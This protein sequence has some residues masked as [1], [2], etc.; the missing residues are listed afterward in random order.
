VVQPPFA[1]DWARVNPL[2]C[3]F[4]GDQWEIAIMADKSKIGV[5]LPTYVLKVERV[6]IRELMRAIGDDN[7]I[8]MDKSKAVA[9]AYLDTPC[10]PT[11][12]TMA[13]Q[14]FTGAYL[15]IFKMLD[16]PLEHV[17]HGEEEY[18]YTGEIFPGD[19]LSCNMSCESIVEK[20]TKSG[21]LDLIT[22]QTIFTNQKDQTVLKARS[23]IIER[24]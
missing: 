14:E 10:P 1:A 13:F 4:N 9:E 24:L 11:Y 16:V 19:V 8:Y 7:P 18:E 17:L 2:F 6:K 22:L 15:E 5:K 12:I 21:P 3:K 20:E 23:L